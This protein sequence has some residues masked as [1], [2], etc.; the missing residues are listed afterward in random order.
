ML[1]DIQLERC[2]ELAELILMDVPDDVIIALPVIRQSGKRFYWGADVLSAL[3]DEEAKQ[4]RDL[5]EKSYSIKK[6]KQE[7]NKGVSHE[8]N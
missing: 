1:N 8:S 5:I 3:G 4:Q 7:K 6:M 2:Y